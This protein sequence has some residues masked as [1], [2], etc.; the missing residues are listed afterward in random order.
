MNFISLT[1]WLWFASGNVFWIIR[2]SRSSLAVYE[3]K[4]RMPSAIAKPRL[5]MSLHIALPNDRPIPAGI[6]SAL[7]NLQDIITVSGGPTWFGIV[8][9]FTSIEACEVGDLMLFSLQPSCCTAKLNSFQGWP[10]IP[11][12]TRENSTTTAANTINGCTFFVFKFN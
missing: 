12:P 4:Y 9:N 3:E 10:K 6:S 7:W 5:S 8:I 11:A 1:N 2:T